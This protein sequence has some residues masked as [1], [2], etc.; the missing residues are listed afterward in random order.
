MPPAQRSVACGFIAL[1]APQ[2][3]RHTAASCATGENTLKLSTLLPLFSLLAVPALAD[4]APPPIAPAPAPAPAKPSLPAQPPKAAAIPVPLDRWLV[5]KETA[6]KGLKKGA[7][8]RLRLDGFDTADAGKG[9]VNPTK[10]TN[11][12]EGYL[13]DNGLKATPAPG[14]LVRVELG[15]LVLTLAAAT[16]AEGKAFSEWVQASGAQQRACSEAANCCIAAEAV[17]GKPCDLHAVLGDRK[18]ETCK[19]AFDKVRAAVE[20]KKAAMPASCAKTM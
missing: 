17:L 6:G 14:Q 11:G 13:C 2:R 15:P 10:C 19:A 4:L 16:D 12:A 3:R 1:D 20:A 18:L 7:G 5:V 8:V 9:S